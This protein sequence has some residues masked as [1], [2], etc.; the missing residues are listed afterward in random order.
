MR[1]NKKNKCRKYYIKQLQEENSFSFNINEQVI[2]KK[3]HTK[4]MQDYS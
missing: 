1:K 3:I 2:I 4:L